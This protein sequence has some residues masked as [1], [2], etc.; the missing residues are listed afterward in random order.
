MMATAQSAINAVQLQEG[1]IIEPTNGGTS[2]TIGEAG[3][4]EAVIP[5]DEPEASGLLGGGDTQ[6]FIDGREL[7]KEFYII[8]TEQLST[9]E[10]QGR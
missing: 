10:L 7:A 5:L 8:N 1:G 3:G 2:A 6:V 4:A 9:G